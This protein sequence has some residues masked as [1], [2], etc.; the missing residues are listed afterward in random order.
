MINPKVR[1][2]R[3]QLHKMLT[4]ETFADN[5]NNSLM[6][7]KPDTEERRGSIFNHFKEFMVFKTEQ[8]SLN[9]QLL[10]RLAQMED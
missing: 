8:K 3:K 2:A 5:N 7:A 10:E 1:K 4:T 6:P 9:E